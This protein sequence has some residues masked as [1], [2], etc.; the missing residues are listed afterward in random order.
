MEVVVERFPH[1][2][3]SKKGNATLNL[4]LVNTSDKARVKNNQS[5]IL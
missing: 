2:K 3:G 1:Q 4:I 5:G